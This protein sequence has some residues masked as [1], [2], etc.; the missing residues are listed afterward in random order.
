[1]SDTGSTLVFS[2]SARDSNFSNWRQSTQSVVSMDSLDLALASPTE[3]VLHSR[4]LKRI[5]K[6][7]RCLGE[8]PP[9]E[10]V[11][12]DDLDPS[13]LEEIVEEVE[14]ETNQKPEWIF[15]RKGEG[16]RGAIRL[17]QIFEEEDEELRPRL[18][19]L[20]G[21]S[22]ASS[23][24]SSLGRPHTPRL[25]PPVPHHKRVGW[26]KE[27]GRKKE[28]VEVENIGSVIQALRTL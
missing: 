10:I 19:S 17:D 1:M 18:P 21:P 25:E 24:S 20:S 23:S 16:K 9:A 13:F 14:K 11:Y 28:V 27:V 7:T 2:K 3:E 26:I 6:L 8:C 15:M 5:V 22:S 4:K 12:G